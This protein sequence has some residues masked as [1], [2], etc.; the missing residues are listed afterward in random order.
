MEHLGKVIK[1]VACGVGI[2][3]LLPLMGARQ[4]DMGSRPFNTVTTSSISAGPHCTSGS[5]SASMLSCTITTTASD[6]I[7]LLTTATGITSV[8]DSLGATGVLIENPSISAYY[9]ANVAA[10]SH[11][12]TVNMTSQSYPQMTAID[13]VGAAVTSPVD[14]YIS[15]TQS[16]STTAVTSGPITTTISGDM[17][18]GFSNGEGAGGSWTPGSPAFSLIVGYYSSAVSGTL[19]AGSPGS[20]TFNATSSVS[21]P[22]NTLLVAIKPRVTVTN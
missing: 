1:S 16:T 17:L 2:A 7:V 19:V 12:I 11:V 8:T 9:F 15:N 4:W 3:L 5:P 14:A 18:V 21:L 22:W 20:Y 6:A 10:G 13:I